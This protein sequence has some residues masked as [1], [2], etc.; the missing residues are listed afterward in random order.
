MERDASCPD[1]R[2]FLRRLAILGGVWVATPGLF[3]EE[4]AAAA[5]AKLIVTPGMTEGP[6]YPDRMPLDT[7]NDLLIVNDAITPAV[8]DVSYVSGRVLSASGQPLRNAFVEIWQCDKNGSYRHSRGQNP[9]GSHDPNFQGYGRFMT[10]SKGEYLFR[11]IKP[12]P[13]DVGG[14]YR[15]PH[16]HFA[17]SRNG[18]RLI[19]TQ[20]MVRGHPANARDNILSGVRDQAARESV[21]VDFQTMAGSKSGEL[22]ASFDIVLGKTAEE[23]ETG[24]LQGGIGGRKRSR[25]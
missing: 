19:T 9:D 3:A 12:V 14:M 11:T 15:A 10:G 22:S 17:V 25:K 8:G 21:L 20:M 13:Y 4:L 16:I 24:K 6:F 7:D 23:D 18:Q 2:R 5:Q 1:R